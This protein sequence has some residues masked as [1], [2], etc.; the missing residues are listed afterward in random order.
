ML[1]EF[2]YLQTIAVA[3]TI[4]VFQHET[5]SESIQTLKVLPTLFGPTAEPKSYP[6]LQTEQPTLELNDN[7][8]MGVSHEVPISDRPNQRTNWT[9]ANTAQTTVLGNT[10]GALNTRYI[11]TAKKRAKNSFPFYAYILFALVPIFTVFI[12]LR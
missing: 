1:R 12:L 3:M 4:P 10:T 5:Q 6:L 9:A 7:I 8:T 2:L 11:I